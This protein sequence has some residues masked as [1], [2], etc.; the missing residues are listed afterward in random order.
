[1]SHTSSIARNL[2]NNLQ[3]QAHEILIIFGVLNIKVLGLWWGSVEPTEIKLHDFIV[4]M[5]K[6]VSASFAYNVNM[7]F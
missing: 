3:N 7:L 5:L 6:L 4:V 1:M 2:N